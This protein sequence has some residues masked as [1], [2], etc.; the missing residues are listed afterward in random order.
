MIVSHVG[1]HYHDRRQAMPSAHERAFETQP[2]FRHSRR[3]QRLYSR[4]DSVRPR[5]RMARG[6]GAHVCRVSLSAA[7]SE[8]KGVLEEDPGRSDMQVLLAKA[9]YRSGQKNDA[10]DVAS[11]LLRRYPYC[12]DANR[13]LIEILGSERPESAQVY[14]QRVNELDPARRR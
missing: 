13:V 12:L 5:I 3:L 8:I 1:R 6:A 7:I 2:S 4:H 10:A 9:Y 14:R 11:A